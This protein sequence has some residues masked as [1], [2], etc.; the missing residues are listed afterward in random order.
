MN[1]APE[2]IIDNLVLLPDYYENQSL[3]EE[4]YRTELLQ[5][6]HPIEQESPSSTLYTTRPVVNEQDERTRIQLMQV[7][8]G[9]SNA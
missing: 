1:A 9:A 3:I 5:E 2:I 6:G 8:H 4:H 7:L